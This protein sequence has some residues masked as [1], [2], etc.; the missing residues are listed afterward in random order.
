MSNI[1]AINERV[2]ES[3]V[4]KKLLRAVPSKFLHIASTTEQF[5]NLETMSVEETIR[6]L[7]AHDERLKGQS[8]P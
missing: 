5:G 7:K 6:S 2:T 1:R 4:V 3:Y 8:G